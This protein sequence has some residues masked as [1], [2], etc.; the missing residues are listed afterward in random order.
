MSET[1]FRAH[2]EP[3]EQKHLSSTKPNA[4]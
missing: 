3:Q 2:T 1:K 4:G